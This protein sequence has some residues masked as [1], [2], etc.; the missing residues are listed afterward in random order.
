MDVG[1]RGSAVAV[2]AAL[3]NARIAAASHHVLGQ[4]SLAHDANG[5]PLRATLKLSDGTDPDL[6]DLY[7]PM[8]ERETNRH[9]G[10]P[11]RSTPPP[12][13]CWST[14]HSEKAR[15]Y[16]FSLRET[17]WPARQHFWP[18]PTAPGT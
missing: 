1:F 9:H 6:A 10:S 17:V 5:S 12:S 18:P 8:L 3:M 11:G 2:G 16:T 7:Q 15:S 4:V 14:P 13:R